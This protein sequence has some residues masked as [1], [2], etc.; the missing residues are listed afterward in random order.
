[1]K[2]RSIAKLL[3]GCFAAVV[4][5]G[6]VNVLTAGSKHVETVIDNHQLKAENGKLK[7]ENT[8]LKTTSDL[9]SSKLV[10]ATDSLVEAIET[11]DSALKIMEQDVAVIK[12]QLEHEKRNSITN[13]YNTTPYQLEPVELPSPENH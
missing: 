13:P 6:V 10:E 9:S 4:V 7:E 1:M 2:G 3:F 5:L 12:T 8:K 11:K